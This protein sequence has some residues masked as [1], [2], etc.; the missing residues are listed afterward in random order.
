VNKGQDAQLAVDHPVTD[1]WRIDFPEVVYDPLPMNG[2]ASETMAAN[3]GDRDLATLDFFVVN[4]KP[5]R[6]QAENVG[7][8]IYEG[9]VSDIANTIWIFL[10]GADGV[11]DYPFTAAHEAGHCLL[12]TQ[13]HS[14]GLMEGGT[15][16]WDAIDATKRITDDQSVQAR[17]V[18]PQTRL[19]RQN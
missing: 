13:E 15:S 9:I 12:D 6:A 8:E 5:D 1:D 17:T 2:W 16:Q 19:L 11:P 10:P 7:F 3:Y 14:S 4:Q 18:N